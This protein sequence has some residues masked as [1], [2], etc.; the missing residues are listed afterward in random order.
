MLNNAINKN[1]TFTPAFSA[2]IEIVN[3]TDFHNATARKKL[4]VAGRSETMDTT[5]IAKE[6]YTTGATPCSA[7]GIENSEQ[8]CMFHLKPLAAINNLKNV[9]KE[10]K[11]KLQELN[12]S[13]E[14]NTSLNGLITGG[15]NWGTSRKL[16]D[17]LKEFFTNDMKIDFSYIWGQKILT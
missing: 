15:E 1:N 13:L 17:E 10:F 14:K 2:R 8:V 7:G 9:K 5:L 3:T 4:L 11:N 16:F 6:T 12:N